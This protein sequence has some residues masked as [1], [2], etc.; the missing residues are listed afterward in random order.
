MNEIQ[1]LILG[2]IQGLTELLPISSSAHLNL[3]PWLFNWGEMPNSFDV[4]LHIGTLLAILIF[5]FKDWVALIKGGYNQVVKKEKTTEGRIFWY[6]VIATIPAG[7][8]SL[9]LDKVSEKIIELGA[10]TFNIQEISVEMIL[11]SIA[12]I[13]M[14]IILY[15]VDKKSKSNKKYEDITLKQ[16]VL[17]S[18][19]QAI[20][21]AFP[22]VS[23][24][25]I[26]MT[27]GRKMNIER[28][29]VA[30]F[31]F[32]LSTPIVAA[33]AL[34][35]LKDFVF[36][37]PFVIGVLASFIVGMLVI[38]FLLNYL[39]KGS[40]KIFAIYRVIL[41]IIILAICFIRL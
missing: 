17:I 32:L 13:V 21:A 36:N 18:M 30:K 29:S 40:F 2:I 33:A 20:A 14:G 34:Y 11:I 8:L 31:S 7:I 1:A 39:K 16:A 37:L 3:F 23:R 6:I 28:E 9:I 35:K 26:T 10:K 24:S 25:G 27:V 38:K 15:V 12:L 5:F 41:G 19:S 4:A 22:G